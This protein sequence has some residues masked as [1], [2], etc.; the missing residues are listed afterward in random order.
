[1]EAFDSRRSDSSTRTHYRNISPKTAAARRLQ[2]SYFLLSSDGLKGSILHKMV[3]EV[4]Q[5]ECSFPWPE[6]YVTFDGFT[7][8]NFPQN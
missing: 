7:K 5:R 6:R 2:R 3:V 1:M 8:L 4:F